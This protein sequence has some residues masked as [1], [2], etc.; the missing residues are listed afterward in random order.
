MK[1]TLAQV[2]ADA[3]LITDGIVGSTQK[4]SAYL[5][6]KEG[7]TAELLCTSKEIVG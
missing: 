5:L 3:S 1:N 6:G 4:V 7:I 2:L